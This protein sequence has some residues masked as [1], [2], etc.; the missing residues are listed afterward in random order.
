MGLKKMEVNEWGG[1]WNFI[2][3]SICLNEILRRLAPKNVI[4]LSQPLVL[5]VSI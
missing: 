2:G 5:E 3:I 1:G 4:M